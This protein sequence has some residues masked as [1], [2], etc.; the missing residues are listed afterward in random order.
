MGP[1]YVQLF[2]LAASFL[3]VLPCVATAR[4]IGSNSGFARLFAAFNFSLAGV[5]GAFAIYAIWR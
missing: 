5:V 1:N 4:L 3:A 2:Q